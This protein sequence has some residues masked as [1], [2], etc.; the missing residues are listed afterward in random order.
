MAFDFKNFRSE[1]NSS[2]DDFQFAQTVLEGLSR[3]QKRLP[4]WLIFDDRGSEIFKE[5]TELENYHPSVCEFEIFHAHKQTIVDI[6]SRE[7]FQLIELGAGD[8]RKTLVLLEQFL[9]NGMKIHY[10]PILYR[11]TQYS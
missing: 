3:E 11:D 5:I 10:A 9:Q 2:S 1:T 8:G 6:L 7:S 4:S